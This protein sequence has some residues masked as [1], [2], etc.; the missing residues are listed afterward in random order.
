LGRFINRIL[1][2]AIIVSLILIIPS[3]AV[4][5]PPNTVETQGIAT[6]TVAS[7]IGDFSHHSDLRWD[8]SSE[9]LG[10]NIEDSPEGPIVL[11]EPPLFFRN[12]VQMYTTYSE[13]TEARDGLMEYRKETSVDTHATAGAGFN[14]ENE[15]LFA[16]TGT[17]T[18]RVLSTENLMMF[19]VGTT[20]DTLGSTIC[21][22][23]ADIYDCY[24]YFCNQVETG[25][26]IDMSIVS[27]GSSAQLRNVNDP[28]EPGHWP[29][30]PTVDDPARMH[31]GIRVTENDGV[32]SSGF[33]SAYLD[34]HNL[35]GE[36]DFF[37]QL[38]QQFDLEENRMVSGDVSTF[39][40]LV[41]YES[42]I[43]R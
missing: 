21:P 15:R 6:S 36:T 16:F 3:I 35:E 10:A 28:G 41:Q 38:G 1:S 25:S 8:L 2:V 5:L 13:D 12:E 9:V 19:N 14:V 27:A 39:S 24:P 26:T 18:G 30:M 34:I 40:Y 29:P 37:D 4:I 22:F 17:D 32:P 23:A 31:Y 43:V 20:V 7:V 33:V 11:P 42:G